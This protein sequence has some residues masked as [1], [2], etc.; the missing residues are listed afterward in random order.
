MVKHE[1]KQVASYPRIVISALY[2]ANQCSTKT[3]VL[4]EEAKNLY[5]KNATL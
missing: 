3:P 2:V 1:S 5:I 4:S